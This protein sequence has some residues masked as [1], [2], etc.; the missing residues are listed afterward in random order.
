MEY[1]SRSNPVF[2]FIDGPPFVSSE[3]LHYGHILVS[4]VKSAILHHKY[5]NGFDIQ[6]TIGYDC[7]GLPIEMKINDLLN[8]KTVEDIEKYGI[9]EYNQKCKEFIDKCQTSWVPIYK[10]IGRVVDENN[11]YRTVDENFM[12]TVWRV[13]KDLWDAGLI[14]KGKRI[15]PYSIA[16]GTS[17]SNFEAS[18]NYK[19][20]SDP[21]V[22]WKFKINDSENDY[23]VIWTTTPWTLPANQAVCINSNI[24]YSLINVDKDNYWIATDRLTAFQN[25]IKKSGNVVMNIMGSEL[26]SKKYIGFDGTT[27]SILSDSYVSTDSGTGIVHIAPEFG[28]DDLRVMQSNNMNIVFNYINDNG[29]V[30][31]GPY[32]GESVLNTLRLVL[33]DGVEN[34]HLVAKESYK[35]SYP[36]CW[37]TDTPLIYRAMDSLFIAVSKIK[38]RLVELNKTVNWIPG[39]VGEKRFHDWL[40]NAKDWGVSRNRI[41]GT[42]IPIWVNEDGDYICVSEDDVSGDLHRDNIDDIVIERNGKKYTR[43]PDVFDCW[44]ESGCVPFVVG[45]HSA[46]LI[47][48]GIDQTR[49]WF[50]TLLVLWTALKN[51]APYKNVVSC[52]LILAEDGKKMSKRLN[53]YRDVK[54]LLKEHG[55]DAMRL[56][57]LNS[58]ATHG[59]AFKFVEKDMIKTT[60]RLVPYKNAITFWKQFGKGRKD[61]EINNEM[62]KWIMYELYLLLE[63]VNNSMNKY[64]VKE[65][66]QSILSFVDK[67]C[68]KYLRLMR[69]TIRENGSG[70]LWN[71]LEIFTLILTP[72]AP[73]TASDIYREL[74]FEEHPLQSKWPVMEVVMYDS[75]DVDKMMDLIET[76]RQLRDKAR[77]TIKKPIA[78]VYL[79]IEEVKNDDLIQ[80]FIKE[81]NVMDIVWN[82]E[83]VKIDTQETPEIINEYKCRLVN[84]AICNL[85]KQV[86]LIQSDYVEFELKGQKFLE[87]VA[88][89]T[90]F[91]SKLCPVWYLGDD[92]SRL[93][94]VSIGIDGIEDGEVILYK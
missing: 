72:F 33:K 13:F 76:V 50:Y 38:D 25:T 88:N 44:F 45:N 74:G 85:R 42:P 57:L 78:Q 92:K 59:E 41:F 39:F 68:N 64:M 21:A 48:E 11:F 14:I 70:V 43:I 82:S 37:R 20:V 8:L 51:E 28:E 55:P 67:L 83:E 81:T 1:K 4:T 46:D 17:L 10:G 58:S 90:D 7:H 29:I 49:G 18:Q 73:F 91:F 47:V 5:M 35:H 60:Q 22:Y 32:K 75:S 53:N 84:R 3:T 19:D 34:G 89:N 71:V 16:C 24:E 77:V 6:N 36:Y 30:Q 26:C 69:D 94:S 63:E 23:I 86:G 40:C 80:L 56:Y 15:V 93:G 9:K 54:E 27:R 2:R 12:R 87:F 61:F 79:N 31:Y 52:G 62:D 65:A 66:T